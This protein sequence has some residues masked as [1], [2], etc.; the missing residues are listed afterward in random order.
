MSKELNIKR[1]NIWID[2]IQKEFPNLDLL[3][4]YNEEEEIFE[5]LL[6]KS[7]VIKLII[8]MNWNQIKRCIT[9]F[10]SNELTCGVCYEDI[11][12]EQSKSALFRQCPNCTFK[13]CLRCSITI[14]YHNNYILRCPQCKQEEDKDTDLE[15]IDDIDEYINL[16]HEQMK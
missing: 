8:T 10:I 3:F 9:S 1:Y 16:L 13:T 15:M 2:L 5:C 6:N 11:K 4:R 12:Q 7:L 14:S